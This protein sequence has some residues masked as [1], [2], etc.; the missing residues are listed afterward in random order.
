MVRFKQA[1]FQKSG[2]EVG[3]TGGETAGGG[4][5]VRVAL[6][7]QRYSLSPSTPFFWATLPRL[8]SLDS[9]SGQI[10]HSTLCVSCL[11]S[12]GDIHNN[13]MLRDGWR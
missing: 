1:K 7:S 9:T 5:V 13:F 8:A 3:A 12:L 4:E 2:W 6:R 11:H 10:L